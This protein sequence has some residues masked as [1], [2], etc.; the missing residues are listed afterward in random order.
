MRLT[1]SHVSGRSGSEL[2]AATAVP[3]SDNRLRWRNKSIGGGVQRIY[4]FCM[5]HWF[6]AEILSRVC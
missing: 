6:T 3:T 5:T 1:K 2:A 4:V